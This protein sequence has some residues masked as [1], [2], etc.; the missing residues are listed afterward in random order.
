MALE[1]VTFRITGVSPLLMN[2]PAVMKKPG[3][4]AGA[5]IKKIPLPE[6]EAA[7][8]VY[9]DD[10]G[11]IYGPATGFKSAL[12]SAAKGRKF[13]KTSAPALLKG[14]VFCPVDVERVF[15][16]HP[17]SGKPLTDSDYVVDSRRAVLS[18]GAKKVGVVRSRPRF[19]NWA[20][21][22]TLEIE[23]EVVEPKAV[24][25][26]LQLA[27]RTIGYLDFRP[28]KGGS[29]GRFEAKLKK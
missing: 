15:L 5:K 19:E 26:M 25:D 29:F 6:E 13:G 24:E 23:T 14:T 22:V 27:G 12:I 8:L 7:R 21:D 11:R 9:R 3:E 18:S 16:V 4:D 10:K 17:K 2:N 28:E 20:C 1:R